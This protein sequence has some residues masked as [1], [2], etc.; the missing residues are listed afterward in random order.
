MELVAPFF[1]RREDVGTA[2]SSTMTP[3]SSLLPSYR[4]RPVGCQRGPATCRRRPVACG[5]RPSVLD[6]DPPLP[7]S[8]RLF[9]I[10]TRRLP[11]SRCPCRSP[12]VLGSRPMK[13][14]EVGRREARRRRRNE[15]AS[16]LSLQSR[17]RSGQALE[18]KLHTLT[19]V[20][21]PRY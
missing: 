5:L 10:L 11:R 3:F 14:G 1:P 4:R 8:T 13:G 9:L 7:D 15:R 18:M 17:K 12:G 6:A 19:G 2:P 16:L 21:S 20:S